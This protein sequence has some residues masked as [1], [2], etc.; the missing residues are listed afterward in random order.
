MSKPPVRARKIKALAMPPEDFLDLEPH[1]AAAIRAWIT[2]QADPDQQRLAAK[3]VVEKISRAY[4]P[5][6]R[7][8]DQ[9]GARASAYLE[10]RRSVGLW[11]VNLQ[12]MS[13]KQFEKDEK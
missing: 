6:Y 13:P 8:E 12:H 10:G 2:G 11:I 5:T 9:G 3:A 1:E 7:P 4:Q